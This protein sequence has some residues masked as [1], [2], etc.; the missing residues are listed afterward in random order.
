MDAE[1]KGLDV[2]TLIYRTRGD[3]EDEVGHITDAGVFRQRWG[4]GVLIGRWERGEDDWR[5]FRNTRFGDKELGAIK[6]D[7]T[8]YSHGLF[9]GGALGWLEPDGTVV[10]GGLIFGEE[11][12]GRV[13]GPHLEVAAAALLL[14]F[15][16]EE[17]EAGREM[18]RR[19]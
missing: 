19:E 4:T 1:K 12:V 9:E 16:S 13:E 18:Q 15:V 6:A 5:V 14:I 17:D 7:A 3:G 8:I 11:E 2:C 10:R